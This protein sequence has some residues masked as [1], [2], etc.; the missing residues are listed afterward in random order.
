MSF[1]GELIF[2]TY[3]PVK[4]YSEYIGDGNELIVTHASYLTFKL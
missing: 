4:R 3:K 1:N 2:L